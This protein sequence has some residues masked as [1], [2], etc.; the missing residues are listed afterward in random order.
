MWINHIVQY[1]HRLRHVSLHQWYKGVELTHYWH[2]GTQLCKH[3]FKIH[4]NYW[5]LL[6]LCLLGKLCMPKRSKMSPYPKQIF[7]QT[8][9]KILTG[10]VSVKLWLILSVECICNRISLSGKYYCLF[11][12]KGKVFQ[13]QVWVDFLSWNNTTDCSINHTPF[14]RNAFVSLKNG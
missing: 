4:M 5:R 13:K 11:R 9:L 10:H 7:M 2:I 14:W 1:T 8:F 12:Q 3:F 6:R